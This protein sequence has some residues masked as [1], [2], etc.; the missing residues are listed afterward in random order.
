MVFLLLTSAALAQQHT[1]I[2]A[3]KAANQCPSICG[4]PSKL[5]FCTHVDWSS[6]RTGASWQEADQ[7][8]RRRVAWTLNQ[9]AERAAWGRPLPKLERTAACKE[10]VRRLQCLVAFPPCEIAH[11]TRYV[12]SAKCQQAVEPDEAMRAGA[13][14]CHS[15]GF[16]INADFCRNATFMHRAHLPAPHHDHKCVDLAYSGPA[17]T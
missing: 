17:Y 3:Q 10:L 2:A 16:P 11:E 14:E 5:K 7:Q 6:C 4:K 13:G 8:A 15:A 1:Q 9:P 12:C